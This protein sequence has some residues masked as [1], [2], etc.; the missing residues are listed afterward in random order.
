MSAAARAEARRKAI[1]A[2]GQDRLKQLTTSARGEGDPVYIQDEAA[3]RKTGG[4]MG[5]TTLENFLGEDTMMPTPPTHVAG[6]P[7]TVNAPPTGPS[8]WSQEEQ[9]EFFQALMTAQQPGAPNLRARDPPLPSN[10]MQDEAPDP[11]LASMMSAMSKLTG[12]PGG[13][14]M[15]PPAQVARPKTTIQKLMPLI[16]LFASWCL[17]VFFIAFHEPSD[18][19]MMDLVT[20]KSAVF[21][22]WSELKWRPTKGEFGVQAVPFFWALVTLQL[23]L[24]STQ[25]LTGLNPIQIPSIVG[26]ALPHLPA[27]ISAIVMNVLTYARMGNM[28]LNDIAGIVFGMGLFIFI[29]SLFSG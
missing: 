4:T 15:A 20:G 9:Q 6:T 16:H 10:E 29:S 11:A 7:P 22:R 28:F 12:Q 8:A 1:L 5:G 23:V 21:Q 26:L 3:V 2:R 18:Y 13:P 27:N 17:L 25:L 14:A 19:S 24:H